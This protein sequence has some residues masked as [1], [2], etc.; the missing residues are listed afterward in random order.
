VTEAR[1]ETAAGCDPV[2]DP[3]AVPDP[4]EG[5]VVTVTVLTHRGAHREANEDAVV[6]GTRTFAGISAAQPQVV[7][8]PLVAPVVVAVADG[9]GG[10]AAGEVAAEHA[11]RRLAAI[12]AELTS[13]DA[14]VTALQTVSG[15]ITAMGEADSE[16][17]D[18][19]TT[20][21]GLVLTA[22][23]TLWFNVGDSRVYSLSDGY[24]GQL[25]IDDTPAARF[26]EPGESPEPTSIVTQILGRGRVPP[27]AH[28]GVEAAHPGATYLLCSDGL[29][30]LVPLE[31]LEQVLS[32]AAS[33]ADDTVAVKA[34][35]AAAMNAGGRDNITIVLVRRP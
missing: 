24:L 34:L 18:M 8:W 19:G 16:R 35:W 10:H 30:D 27:L 1:T 4:P 29:S 3:G 20:V 25:S 17:T 32:G 21:V 31:Q 13:R 12:G 2:P 22:A 5:P 6:V 23:G 33:A 9:L 7:T 26:A 28:T 14:V 15:E 11:V